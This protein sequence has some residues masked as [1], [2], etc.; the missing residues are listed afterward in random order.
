MQPPHIVLFYV[1]NFLRSKIFYTYF[2]NPFFMWL[3][4]TKFTLKFI[5]IWHNKIFLLIMKKSSMK[6]CNNNKTSVGFVLL[7]LCSVLWFIASS[8]VLLSFWSLYC[9]FFN[10]WILI[11]H[12]VSL[13]FKRSMK[14]RKYGQR[15]Y[16]NVI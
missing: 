12:L 13:N 11:I 9:L 2:W 5:S 4:L 7:D 6:F 8:L 10:F 14:I 1:I 16:I 3:I 15:T